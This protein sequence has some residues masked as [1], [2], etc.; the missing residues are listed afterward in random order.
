MK[1]RRIPP[2][3]D[4][5]GPRPMSP[6][7]VRSLVERARAASRERGREIGRHGAEVR[8]RRAT[9]PGPDPTTEERRRTLAAARDYNQRLRK[10]TTG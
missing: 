9:P 3:I 5:C 6:E 10:V 1:R 7:E 4:P 2:L 8:W